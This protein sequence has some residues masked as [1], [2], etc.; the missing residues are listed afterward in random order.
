[1]VSALFNTT[2]STGLSVYFTVGWIA[3]TR[4]LGDIFELQG[5]YSLHLIM[6]VLMCGTWL[7]LFVLTFM[8]F[9]RG[10]IFKSKPEDVIKDT[11]PEVIDEEKTVG[12]VEL[13]E[14]QRPRSSFGMDMP[15]VHINTPPLVYH[16]PTRF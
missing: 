13:D 14:K 16:Q 6:A 9:W 3:T 15:P 4:V 11:M 1:M 5:F 8:A 10:L 12:S 2:R 7:V